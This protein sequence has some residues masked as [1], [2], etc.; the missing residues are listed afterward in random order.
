MPLS[1]SYTGSKFLTGHS[2]T[3]LGSWRTLLR[4]PRFPR[5]ISPSHG[6]RASA[7]DFGLSPRGSVTDPET[8]HLIKRKMKKT[9]TEWKWSAVRGGLNTAAVARFNTWL[10]FNWYWPLS[11]KPVV[12]TQVLQNADITDTRASVSK[13]N[14]LCVHA[15]IDNNT[16]RSLLEQK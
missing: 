5:R 16:L 8:S 12:R 14:P 11:E 7:P 3:H 9:Q 13:G 2:C 10:A 1:P 4:L 15:H 6:C